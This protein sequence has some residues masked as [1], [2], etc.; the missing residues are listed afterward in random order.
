MMAAVASGLPEATISQV[1]VS[2]QEREP[3]LTQQVL[4]SSGS[5]IKIEGKSCNLDPENEVPIEGTDE[6]QTVTP[7]VNP[8]EEWI[9]KEKPTYCKVCDFQAQSTE[10][11]Q[12]S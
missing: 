2:E 9:D 1:V 7:R 10:V 6:T 4:E 11:S 5:Q 12:F 3:S 8:R